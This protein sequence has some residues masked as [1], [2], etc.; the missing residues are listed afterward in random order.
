MGNFS[1][2]PNFSFAVMLPTLQAVLNSFPGLWFVQDSKDFPPEFQV[3]ER[4]LPGD[5]GNFE[6]SKI[7]RVNP[8]DSGQ[9]PGNSMGLASSPG[10]LDSSWWQNSNL[11]PCGPFCHNYNKFLGTSGVGEYQSP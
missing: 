11:L 6:K 4:V 7:T 1:N 2:F 10:Q 5:F 8:R 9:F 3:L